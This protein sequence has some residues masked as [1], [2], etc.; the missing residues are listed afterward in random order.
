[1]LGNDYG[2]CNLGELRRTIGWVSCAIQSQVPG[3]LTS[4]QV[5]LS[6]IDASVGIY[7]EFSSREKQKAEDLLISTGLAECKDKRYDILSQ[8]QQQRVLIA[9]ALINDL[10]LL[11]LDEPCVGMD[12]AARHSFLSD[13][14][15]HVTQKK[16]PPIIYVTHHVEEIGTWIDNVIVLKEGEIVACGDKK[17]VLTG[18]ILSE[19]FDCRCSVETEEGIY[20]M[21]IEDK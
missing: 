6:G 11:I 12:P 9:R 14:Q 3:W 15:N 5:V 2:Q 13:I 19:A 10:K 20:R 7:R 16:S 4:I 8:G 21:K 17:K 1:M 18:E